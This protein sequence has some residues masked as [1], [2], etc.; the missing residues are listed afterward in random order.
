MKSGSSDL[1]S[2]LRIE[3]K[4]LHVEA[5]RS[6]YVQDILK[7]RAS[8]EGYALY[9]RNLLPVYRVLEHALSARADQPGL[10]LF[11]WPDLFRSEAIAADLAALAGPS[12]EERLPALAANEIYA[13]R[14]EHIQ[15]AEPARLI[16][17]AYVRYIGDLSGGQIVKALLSRWLGLEP[18]MLGFY[19]FAHITDVEAYKS[20]FRAALDRAGDL[21][22][23]DA[24]VDEAKRA[25]RHNIDLSLAV[26]RSM[27]AR[28]R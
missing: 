27:T 6:G 14:I 3:T 23:A 24:V 13:D 1:A 19:D 5:E 9:I 8:R 22:E 16:G 18:G 15:A 12:W 17:H 25:F 2:R 21:A 10:D 7:G 20:A 28:D 11:R 4:A 26:Q